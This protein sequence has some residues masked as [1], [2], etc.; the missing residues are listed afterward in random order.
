[1]NSLRRQRRRLTHALWIFLTVVMIM[2]V[3]VTIITI[4]VP[5]VV[6][7]MTASIPPSVILVPAAVPLGVQ[8]A[9][10]LVGLLATRPVSADGLVEPRFRFLNLMFAFLPIVPVP[11]GARHADRKQ[12][13]GACHPYCAGRLHPFPTVLMCDHGTPPSHFRTLRY[14]GHQASCLPTLPGSELYST[15]SHRPSA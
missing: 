12:E 10:A 11:V 9:P 4:P 8:V 3:A 7:L 6:P 2:I 13:H 15:R 5:L 14:G 1:M